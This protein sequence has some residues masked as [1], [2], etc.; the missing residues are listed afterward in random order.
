MKKLL[1]ILTLLLAPSLAYA[2]CNGVFQ[3]HT[4]CG[5]PLG[6]AA[7]PQQMPQSSFTGIPGGTSGQIQYNNAGVF[8]GLTLP[9]INP[10]GR[11]TL[12][13]NTPE[14]NIDSIGIQNLF[15]TP[16]VSNTVYIYNGSIIAPFTFAQQTLALAGNAAW[17][18]N[19]IF[20]AFEV[21]NGG[22]ATLASRAW[23]ASMLPGA[24]TQITNVTTITSGSTPTN[25]TNPTF[26]FNGTVNQTSAN[27]A[28][29]GSN[30][31]GANCL[32]QD[33][34]AGNPQVVNQIIITAPTDNPLMGS[35]TTYEPINTFGSNDNTNWTL[36]DQR[37]VDSSANHTQYTLGINNSMIV[38]Y[39]YWRECF[40][41]NSINQFIRVG[42]IQFMTIPAPSTRRLNR[43]VGGYLSNDATMT[44]RLDSATT[45]S[46]LA[47]QGTFLGS[48][49][50]DSGSAGQV[51]AYVS[52]GPSRVYNI[53]NVYN[54][55]DI[56]LCAMVP[57]TV[58]GVGPNSYTLSSTSYNYIQ[59][60]STYNFS[61]LIGYALEPLSVT[62]IR[63]A[64]MNTTGNGAGYVAGI[65]LDSNN[66]ISGTELSFTTDSTGQQ[67]GMQGSA[68]LDLRPFFGVHSFFG[69][70]YL[71]Y[72][73]SGTLSVF[74]N[75]LNT[76]LC[77]SWKG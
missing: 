46:V 23:D 48:F 26:A 58:T 76:K 20:D 25:W 73:P 64:Y 40:Q 37:N 38:P 59:N 14:I 65:G 6:V 50:T 49:Q 70:E 67:Q 21:I 13:S 54:R 3:P 5:N 60:T 63:A 29:I 27:S 51:T 32:G 41:G 44:A 11:L 8:D 9:V 55:H 45:I 62:M 34:G 12:I 31:S 1:L 72:I 30:N 22:V 33:F 7:I 42:Q 16:D 17:P 15:Y 28:T 52:P 56:R 35:G 10:G 36:I 43:A 24:A 66:N 71:A 77:G 61:A 57:F 53:W 69:V 2:Q 19:T 39:R 68:S 47:N 75:V 18:A 4:G 74:N